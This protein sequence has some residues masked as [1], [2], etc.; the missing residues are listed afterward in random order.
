MN[1]NY[2]DFINDVIERLYHWCNYYNNYYNK[3]LYNKKK[4]KEYGIYAEF[5]ANYDYCINTGIYGISCISCTK[6]VVESYGNECIFFE[7]F[8]WTKEKFRIELDKV[9]LKIW[10][11]KE[12]NY[13]L[14]KIK[15]DFE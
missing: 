6:K 8:D 1:L 9:I 13:K 12:I 11:E 7:G 10:K 15:E 14:K 3:Y 2:N 4:E 5:R